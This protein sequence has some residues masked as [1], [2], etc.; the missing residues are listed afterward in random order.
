MKLHGAQLNS[1]G[2]LLDAATAGLQALDTARLDAEVLL[3]MILDVGREYCHAHPEAQVPAAAAADFWRLVTR[4]QEGFPV[5]YL[6]GQREFWSLDLSV[7][8]F[9]L[10]PRPETEQLVET[11]L[12]LARTR[13][14]PELL[15][16]GTGSG[17]VS[18]AL[19]RERPDA[20]ITA[21]DLCRHALELAQHNAARHGIGNLSFLVS[22]WYAAL[23]ARRFDLIL[24]NPPYVDE[25]CPALW[26]APLRHEP[27]LA[28]DG[29]RGGLEAVA[30]I[31][32]GAGRHLRPDAYLLLEHGFD[33]GESVRRLLRQYGFTDVETHRDAGGQ[34]RISGGRW[35]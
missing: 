15:E 6:T 28:L 11:A 12:D 29:G 1:V 25:Q 30:R 16:L 10:I 21:T 19:A 34:E 4:R 24:S 5:A 9:T 20:R 3:C 26:Q 17:A 7:N 33:Q 27:R 32:A 13:D 22:D 14:T 18:I 31:I 23:G 2:D 35:Q 8:Q